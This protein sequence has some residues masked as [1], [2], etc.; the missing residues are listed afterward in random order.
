M[1]LS[2]LDVSTWNLRIL[3]YFLRKI[4]FLTVIFSN[5]DPNVIGRKYFDFLYTYRHMPRYLRVDRGNETGI[6]T[7]I[8]AYLIGQVGDFDDPIDS[9]IFGKSTSNKIE[10]WWRDLHERLEGYFKE[11]LKALLDN[12]LYDPENVQDRKMLAYIFIPVIQRECNTFVNIWNE[13]RIR[14]QKDLLLPVGIPDHMFDF[15]ETYGAFKD[16]FPL[17]EENLRDTA[18]ASGVLE[19]SID[20]LEE[21]ERNL[22]G[23][24]IPFP[25]T[26]KCS[27]AVKSYLTLK[28]R[29]P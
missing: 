16:G 19:G 7:A 14:E 5:S 9:V 21:D 29:I 6:M 10:R 27:D 26:I 25:E 28:R 13:H 17:T 23:T 20:F 15:P 1:W 11:Q 3:G 8:H 18:E 12:H 22:F 2:K 4:V 24:V